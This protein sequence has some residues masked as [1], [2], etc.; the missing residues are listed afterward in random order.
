MRKVPLFKCP[1]CGI[2][3]QVVRVESDEFENTEINCIVCGCPLKG[4][5]GGSVLKYFLVDGPRR[6][7]LDPVAQPSH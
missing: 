2:G 5:E 7:F 3:Y 6:R 1:Q 4:S